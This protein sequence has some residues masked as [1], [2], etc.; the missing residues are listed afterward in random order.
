MLNYLKAGGRTAILEP[1]FGGTRTMELVCGILEFVPHART[2][3]NLKR[4]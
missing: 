2:M 3:A 4:V 1:N